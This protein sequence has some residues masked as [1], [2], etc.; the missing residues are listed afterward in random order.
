MWERRDPK[1]RLKKINPVGPVKR[2]IKREESAY[3]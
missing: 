2:R 3:S 1:M